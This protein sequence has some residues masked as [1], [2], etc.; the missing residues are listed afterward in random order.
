MK[1]S[2]LYECTVMHHRL[3]PKQNR[4][5]YKLF[6][7]YLDLDEIGQVVNDNAFISHN[8]FNLFNFREKDHLQFP[9]ENPDTTKSVKEQ[10]FGYL[11]Q[12]GTNTSGIGKVMLLTNLCTLGYQ[13]NPVSFYFCY[14]K[15]DQPVC[16]VVEVCNTYREMK[17]FFLGNEKLEKNNF[18]NNQTKNFYV[19]PFIDMDSDF[20]FNL[21]IP[22]EKLHVRI[23]DYKNGKR[24]FLSTLTGKKKALTSWS[25]FK[26]AIRFPIITLQVI[27]LIHWQALRLWL[28]KISHHKKTSFK[29][30]Q[31]GVLRP[32]KSITE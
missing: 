3:E 14:D 30:L 24:F 1:N 7:F 26:Y 21:D 20:H 22:D 10:V 5:H 27:T 25:T 17:P 28:K 15:N 32:H 23:D 31:Q 29:E 9:K 4:F 16:S 13:F 12:N 6:M 19:S 8:R 11:E 2:C 18:S